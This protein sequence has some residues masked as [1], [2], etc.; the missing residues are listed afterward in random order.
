MKDYRYT[1]LCV[2]DEEGIL[3]A[4]KRVLR[5]ENYRIITA[6]NSLDGTKI[7]SENDVQLVI[8]DQRMPEVSGTEFLA[9]V[10]DQ[11]PDVVR[12]ILSGY[13]D[14]DSI[15]ESVNKGHIYKFLLKPWNDQ[16]LK[17]EIKQALEYYELKN[18][19]RLLHEQ[20]SKQNEK[21]ITYNE[22]LEDIVKSRTEELMIKNHM[23]EFSRMIMEYMPIPIIGVSLE[24]TLVLINQMACTLSFSGRNIIVGNEISD[25]FESSVTKV[26]NEC[27][28]NGESQCF[29]DYIIGEDTYDIN[30][31]PLKGDSGSRGA[32][33]SLRLKGA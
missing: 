31:T 21:L 27:I 9:A 30:F 28:E 7:L 19:N 26:F 11:F 29:K 10:N 17:L 15:T 6:T 14:V 25:Y 12:I 4:L 32:I 1:I 18:A 22:A 23:L 5:G 16:T 2:D 8:C 13:T 20:V 3:S 24:G 33:L